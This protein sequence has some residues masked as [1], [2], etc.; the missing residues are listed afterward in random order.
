MILHA[1]VDSHHRTWQ[2][3][4]LQNEFLFIKQ[5]TRSFL[6]LKVNVSLEITNMRIYIR[7]DDNTLLNSLNFSLHSYFT[8][9]I[10][11]V[12]YFINAFIILKIS[13]P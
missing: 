11:T 8:I 6:A 7:L 4:F 1:L 5:Q 9:H 13:L 3:E 12:N 10:S 2:K